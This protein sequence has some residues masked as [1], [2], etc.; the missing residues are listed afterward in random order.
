MAVKTYVSNNYTEIEQEFFNYLV[1]TF[2]EHVRTRDD[3]TDRND[4]LLLLALLAKTLGNSKELI[5]NL[6]KSHSL[7]EL[8]KD[9]NLGIN[10]ENN[11][12][13]L[14][15]FADDLDYNILAGKTVEE[16]LNIIEQEEAFIKITPMLTKYRGTKRYIELLIKAFEEVLGYPLDYTIEY[17]ENQVDIYF[18][19]LLDYLDSDTYVRTEGLRDIFNM[20]TDNNFNRLLMY[21]KPAGSVYNAL[22]TAINTALY[23]MNSSFI[24]N[25]GETSNADELEVTSNED[26]APQVIS[27]LTL[28]EDSEGVPHDYKVTL[29]NTSKLAARFIEIAHIDATEYNLLGQKYFSEEAIPHETIELAPDS[30]KEIFKPLRY[31]PASSSEYIAYYITDSNDHNVKS[32]TTFVSLSTLLPAPEP[33]LIN[34]PFKPY[35]MD[36]LVPYYDNGYA[37]TVII[38][39]NSFDVVATIE[40]SWRSVIDNGLVSRFTETIIITAGNTL[41]KNY[42]NP[43]GEYDRK[44]DINV[45][46]T[47]SGVDSNIV[48]SSQYIIGPD[49]AKAPPSSGG[50]GSSGPE[51][52][53]ELA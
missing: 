16:K 38:N 33:V 13:L 5:L 46:F 30:F 39:T 34:D 29:N 26:D 44:I 9:I 27:A 17:S 20:K 37:S 2:P 40:V 10:K 48:Y 25:V 45:K 42:Y 14:V 15:P 52:L 47:F 4:I 31:L 28:V 32:S 19:D 49:P 12:R 53:K 43:S 22:V 41:N 1:K 51:E 6:K 21:Y 23:N 18:N 7:D 35:N 24:V 11:L 3:G 50:G 36:Y 8:Y